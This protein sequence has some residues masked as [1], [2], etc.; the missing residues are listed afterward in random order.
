[1]TA[2]SPS[3]TLARGSSRAADPFAAS[4]PPLYQTATF[5]QPSALEAGPYDYT[6]SGNPTRDRLEEELAR[7]EGCERAFAYTSGIAAVAAVARTV[8]AGGEIVAGDDLYGG[9]YRLLARLIEP[10]GCKNRAPMSM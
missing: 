1:M 9:T 6:R 2:W 10:S 7:L 3:T 4:A 5:A 8:A